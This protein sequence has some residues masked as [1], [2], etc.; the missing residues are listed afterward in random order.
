M[1]GKNKIFL[2]LLFCFTFLCFWFGTNN[3]LDPD[4]GWH[5]RLGQITL[6]QGIP[7]T[8]LFSYTMPHYKMVNHEWLVDMG[9]AK[10]F[11]FFGL[12]GLAVMFSLLAFIAVLI[13][14]VM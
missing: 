6:Q 11:P 13:Q 10:L 5:L 4:F 12:D 9:I 1:P 2:L 3:G 14:A 8:D 7:Q